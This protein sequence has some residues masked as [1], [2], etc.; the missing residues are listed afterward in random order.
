LWPKGDAWG[1]GGVFESAFSIA[2]NHRPA[3]N[4]LAGGFRLHR[5]MRVKLYGAYPGRGEDLPIY[6]SLLARRGWA[7]VDPG[8]R[9]KPQWNADVIWRFERP[10][11]YEHV[12]VRGRRLQMRIRG[13]HQRNDAKYWID[14]AVLDRAGAALLELPRTDWA[15]WDR[16]DLVYGRE[17]KLFRVPEMSFD[18]GAPRAKLIADLN[19]MTFAARA[20]PDSATRWL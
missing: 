17:G 19:D 10:M 9:P 8:D 6:D 3:E 2:L 15:D 18:K 14:Y 5:R 12:G 7:L 4:K 1:G 13:V 16:G 20:A 11:T